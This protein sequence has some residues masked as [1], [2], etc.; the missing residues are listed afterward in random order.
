M[1]NIINVDSN[2]VAKH[3]LLDAFYDRYSDLIDF[4]GLNSFSLHYKGDSLIRFGISSKASE[5]VIENTEN[6]PLEESEIKITNNNNNIVNSR[7]K[8]CKASFN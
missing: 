2:S 5:P 1:E 7:R 6:E 8:P 3:S 4:N